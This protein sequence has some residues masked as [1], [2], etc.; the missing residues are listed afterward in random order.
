MVSALLLVL[1]AATQARP[2]EMKLKVVDRYG[3]EVARYSL[4]ATCGSSQWSVDVSPS[5]PAP[6]LAR[7]RGCSGLIVVIG[8]GRRQ[9]EPR[10][11]DRGVVSL[12]I[13]DAGDPDLRKPRALQIRF[14]QAK[15]GFHSSYSGALVRLLFKYGDEVY[16]APLQAESMQATF[17]V[18]PAGAYTILVHHQDRL[19]V[20]A[21]ID[22][23]EVERSVLVNLPLEQSR[24]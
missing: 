22:V 16:T 5:V 13:A 14:A 21:D 12:T 17:Q 10:E 18:L 23:D 19:V 3:G 1:M 7:L 9:I 6:S 11:F 2:E 20:V 15:A 24:K 4:T 8:F